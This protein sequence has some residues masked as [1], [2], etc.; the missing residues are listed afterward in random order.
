[1]LFNRKRRDNDRMV[2]GF[3]SKM[4]S[5]ISPWLGVLSTTLSELILNF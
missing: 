2:S 5:L 3:P 1:M 4:V